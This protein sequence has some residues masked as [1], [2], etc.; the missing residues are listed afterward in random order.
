VKRDRTPAIL[1]SPGLPPTGAGTDQAELRRLRRGRHL[2]TYGPGFDLAIEVEQVCAPLAVRVMLRDHLSHYA[3]EV[4]ELA[5]AVYLAC[6]TLAAM[7]ARANAAGH[8]SALPVDMRGRELKRIASA[9]SRR[10]PRPVID[11]KALQ[12]GSWLSTLIELVSPLVSPLGRLLGAPAR[13]APSVSQQLEELLRVVDDAAR[14]LARKLKAAECRAPVA[15]PRRV[16]PRTQTECRE[17]R[18]T[19]MPFGW[20]RDFDISREISEICCPLEAALAALPDPGR[21]A[22]ELRKVVDVVHQ[23]VV[24]IA[25]LVGRADMARR[26]AH[27]PIEQRG[28][29]KRLL[30]D[31]AAASPTRPVT[32]KAQMAAGTWAAPLVKLAEPYRE[33]LSQLLTV[34]ARIGG[35]SVSDHLDEALAR[36]DSAALNLTRRIERIEAVTLRGSRPAVPAVAA[37]APADKADKARAE[38]ARLGVPLP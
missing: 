26:V 34:D 14:A 36:I 5:D 8:A 30:A 2:H 4:D 22:P 11:E 18:R 19:G 7:I 23:A 32:S 3:D 25:N 12:T 6:K 9:A 15:P 16:E 37:V 28:S 33:S 20:P 38:L 21:A 1:A 10:V 27:L 24:E 35:E 29:A 31:L 17:A 13:S